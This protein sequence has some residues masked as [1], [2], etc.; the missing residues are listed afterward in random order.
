LTGCPTRFYKHDDRPDKNRLW[1]IIADADARN[2]PMACAV[3]SMMEEVEELTSQD[4]K[5]AGLV[6]AH[7]YTLISAKDVKTDAG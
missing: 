2:F 6:D 4:M 5:Q 3:A 1:K 7:A